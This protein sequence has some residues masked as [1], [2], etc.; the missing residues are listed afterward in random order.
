M[1][2]VFATALVASVP[3]LPPCPEYPQLAPAEKVLADAGVQA[4]LEK[5]KQLLESEAAKL[6]SGL[7]GVIVYNQTVLWRGGFGKR[8]PAALDPPRPSDLVRIASI[9]NCL[10]Y[11][12]P[13]PRD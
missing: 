6:P 10:L 3:H 2:A 11:T 7:T 12:S 13:S 5:V 9:T 4:A 1:L 8:K